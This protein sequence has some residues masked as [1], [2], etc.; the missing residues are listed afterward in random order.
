MKRKSIKIKLADGKQ[1]IFAERNKEDIDISYMQEALR[2]SVF[3][4]LKKYQEDKRITEAMADDLRYVNFSKIFTDADINAYIASTPAEIFKL[5][6]ASF[7]IENKSTLDEFIKLVDL[8]KAKKI[9]NDINE[10]ERGDPLTD[11]ECAEEMGMGLVKFKNL[12]KTQPETYWWL[13]YNV[14]KSLGK[15]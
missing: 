11:K 10:L 9:L 2:E 1:Y 15:K 14:K 13:K 3:D 12:K 4:R 7:K 8:P 6:Y 5:V